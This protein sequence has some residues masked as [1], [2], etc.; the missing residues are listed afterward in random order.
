V[1]TGLSEFSGAI[2]P[3]LKVVMRYSI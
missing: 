3:N 2:A 1:I